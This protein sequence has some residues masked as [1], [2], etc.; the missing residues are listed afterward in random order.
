M[1]TDRGRAFVRWGIKSGAGLGINLALLTVW[2]DWV[3]IW[4]EV[5]VLINWLLLSLYGYLLSLY[6]VFEDVKALSGVRDHLTQWA[7]MQGILAGGKVV[8]YLVYVG[9]L[10]TTAVDYRIAWVIGAVGGLVVSF[11]GNWEWWTPSQ[12]EVDQ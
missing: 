6:W 11:G 5:A 7:G 10:Q 3:G 1:W 9:L 12:S 8:N 2:A 4:P